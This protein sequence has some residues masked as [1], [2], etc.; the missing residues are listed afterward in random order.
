MRLNN[1]W[2]SGFVDGEGCFH[3]SVLKHPEMTVGYQVL[4]EFTVVQHERDKQILFALKEFFKCGVVRRNHGDRWCY[5]VRNLEH[6]NT[7]CEFFE[8]HTLKTKKRIDYVQFR[9]IIYKMNNGEHLRLDG[10][11]KIVDIAMRMNT[12]NRNKLFQIR[13]GLGTK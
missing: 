6:L 12:G 7:L 10:L 9:R 8:K 13:K 11:R 3:V 4:P 1:E 2:I 5:R